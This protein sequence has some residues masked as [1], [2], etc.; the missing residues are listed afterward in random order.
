MDA[1]NEKNQVRWCSRC[2]S[3]EQHPQP[4]KSF[5]ADSEFLQGE[6]KSE[7]H[8]PVADKQGATISLSCNRISKTSNAQIKRPKGHLTNN[9]CKM[10]SLSLPLLWQKYKRFC[11]VVFCFSFQYWNV[12]KPVM[13]KRLAILLSANSLGE[14]IQNARFPPPYSQCTDLGRGKRGSLAD[15]IS[16]QPR[17][18]HKEAALWRALGPG[19]GLFQLSA[20]NWLWL[21]CMVM[22]N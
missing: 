1:G 8:N 11:S 3:S 9:V 12:A 22:R 19:R 13:I 5:S 6:F 16:F 7:F 17:L 2:K 10:T 21:Q 4:W 15:L 14:D 18:G 20:H